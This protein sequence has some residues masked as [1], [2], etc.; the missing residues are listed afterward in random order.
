MSSQIIKNNGAWA[1]IDYSISGPCLCIIDD[2]LNPTA[3]YY[4]TT[5]SRKIKRY[6]GSFS[7]N[8]NGTFLKDKSEFKNDIERF[9]YVSDFFID[10]IKSNNIKNICLEGYSMGSRNGLVFNI[11]EH[12]GILKYKLLQLGIDPII[13]SPK[14]VK[15][16][17]SGTGNATKE[18]MLQNFEEK[19]KNK[20]DIR[21]A[22]GYNKV[23]VES[24][25]SDIV[26]SYYIALYGKT[27]K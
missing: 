2:E 10:V 17:A 13:A 11:A 22:L 15:K 23:K 18:I 7:H 24:P 9:S 27:L 16:F 1:G 5:E 6:V 26:D 19:F 21:I 14:T 3:W 25:I 20:I 8:I 4:L 12:T